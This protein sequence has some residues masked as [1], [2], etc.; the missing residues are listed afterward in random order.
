MRSCGRLPTRSERSGRGATDR[1][2]ALAGRPREAAA[3][4]LDA[5]AIIES[6]RGL[7][8]SEDRVAFFGRHTSPYAALVDSLLVLPRTDDIATL[9]V[10]Y[11]GQSPAEVAFHYAEAARARLLS[12]QIARAFVGA[13][14][15]DLPADVR[16]RERTLQNAAAA[17][18][19]RGV[20]YD[21]SA[22]YADFQSFVET[23]RQSHA[24]YATLK[25]PVPVTARQVPLRD[26]EALIAYAVLERRVAV[27]LLRKGEPLRVFAEPGAARGAAGHGR[28]LPPLGRRQRRQPPD[29]RR[30]RR[31]QAVSLA[32]GRA[33]GAPRGQH[34]GDRGA[35]TAC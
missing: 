4:L 8:R 33:A 19:R 25:Y 27:W 35:R 10:E 13:A 28:G 9:P 7:I 6:L 31:G 11:R 26:N 20:P 14:E 17:E 3:S 23:L 24:D 2:Y 22:A 16:E 12:E 21:G 18:L 34:H 30:G 15:R 1:R 5:V 29:L 32:A